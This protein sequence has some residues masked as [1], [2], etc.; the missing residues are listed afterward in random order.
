[1]NKS[2]SKNSDIFKETLH[3]LCD[4]E[5]NWKPGA[6]P[7]FRI[8]SER[9]KGKWTLGLEDVNSFPCLPYQKLFN[10]LKNDDPESLNDDPEQNDHGEKAILALDQ[11]T[12]SRFSTECVI[13]GLAHALR[14]EAERQQIASTRKCAIEIRNK[15]PLHKNSANIPDR[16]MEILTA[17]MSVNPKATG[18]YL[19]AC[20]F[21][22]WDVR[23]EISAP[24]V[25]GKAR[26]DIQQFVYG[27]VRFPTD[28]LNKRPP[29][30][31]L[32]VV[33]NLTWLFLHWPV[34]GGM[35]PSAGCPPKKQP[36]SGHKVPID[37]KPHRDITAH[38]LNALFPRSDDDVYS[39]KVVKNNFSLPKGAVFCGW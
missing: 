21:D 32:L 29:S 15:E 6:V 7:G 16:A 4:V 28:K 18:P 30:I 11:L 1:V 14:F 24:E 19:L 36:R 2:V 34:T 25:T 12:T 23:E 20:R 13:D 3:R 27:C 17:A 5:A 38:F 8:A 33:A 39:S 9:I 26:H 37:G 35:Y 31:K 22:R 10:C